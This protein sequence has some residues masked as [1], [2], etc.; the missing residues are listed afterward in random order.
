MKFGY[1]KVI[2]ITHSGNL[3]R[4]FS[5]LLIKDMYKLIRLKT[6]EIVPVDHNLINDILKLSFDKN[7]YFIFLSIN[8]VNIFI[9][10][11]K[12]TSRFNDILDLLNNKVKVIAIGL[13]TSN[14]LKK[15]G[16]SVRY[17]PEKFSSE[18]ILK[19]FPRLTQKTSKI[20]IPRS[21]LADN[22]LNENLSELGY[23]VHE[24]YLYNVKNACIDS[25][26][27]EFLKLLKCDY[28]DFLVF[29]SPSN[30]RSFFEII[31]RIS[32][33]LIKNLSNI[34]MVISIGPKTSKELQRHA[35]CFVEADVHSLQGIVN[36]ISSKSI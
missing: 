11:A 36:L 10:F 25:H 13:S 28:I 23:K 14:T 1:Y 19:I 12:K 22:Y 20:I 5:S 18:E 16:V 24:F 32:P 29:T 8:A 4:D 7:D 35:L 34:D 6:T 26:W 17:V 15:N 31:E 21:S 33:D 9:E 3:F 30:V 2:G 27:I